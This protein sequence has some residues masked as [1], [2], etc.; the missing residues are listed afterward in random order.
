MKLLGWMHRKFRQGSGEPLKDFSSGHPPLDD[1]QC[2]PK[3]N[4]YFTKSSS[5]SQRDNHHLLLRKSFADSRTAGESDH[6][7]QY[8]DDEDLQRD[9]S[10]AALSDLFH[11][12]L[13]IGTLGGDHPLG[14]GGGGDP[15]ATPTFSISMDNIAEKETGEVTESDLRMIND[16]L[17][18]VLLGDGV[19]ADQIASGRSSLVSNPRSSHCSTITLSRKQLESIEAAAAAGAA[20]TN[21]CPLQG[22]LLGSAAIGVPET[23]A[24]KKEPRPSLGELFQKTKMVDESS[25]GNKGESN[26]KENDKSSVHH[27]LKKILKKG[28]IHPSSSSKGSS[29]ADSAADT[30]FNKVLQMFHRKVHPESIAATEKL[31]KPSNKQNQLMYDNLLAGGGGGED[32]ALVPKRRMSN[33]GGMRHLKSQSGLRHQ[34]AAGDPNVMN[35]E[36][37]IKSDADYLVLEL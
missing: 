36:C 1:I 21:I 26:K 13:A 14:G 8:Y 33:C 3:A 6:H 17:E 29:N 7:G 27:L 19:A 31:E 2:Y 32:V 35:K 12:F 11:G 16:E 10:A 28:M 25:Y 34:L 9:S 37:W 24:N 22:Y 15:Y 30:K 5:K 4:H 20:A 23:A 18:K